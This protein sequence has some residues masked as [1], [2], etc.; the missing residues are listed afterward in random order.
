VGLPSS[1]V[2]RRWRCAASAIKEHA[3]TQGLSTDSYPSANGACTGPTLVCSRTPPPLQPP[4]TTG[5]FVTRT[6]AATEEPLRFE[7]YERTHA[8]IPCQLID[9]AHCA[10]R[11]SGQHGD[12][13]R[14]GRH[15]GQ[16]GVHC[17][18][19]LRRRLCWAGGRCQSAAD[20]PMCTDV[21][22]TPTHTRPALLN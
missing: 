11:R 12:H 9:G 2:L 3:K 20:T 18:S 7:R 5:Y 8:Q 10:A 14:A 4:P 15:R 19:T 13:G 16:V 1:A 6:E 21:P 17:C 22:V